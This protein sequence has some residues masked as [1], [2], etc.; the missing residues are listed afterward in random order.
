LHD[1]LL[2]IVAMKTGKKCWTGLAVLA[3]LTPGL[4][5][6]IAPPLAPPVPVAPPVAAA[7]AVPAAGG[8][9]RTLW[10]FLGVSK[11]QRAACKE[12]LCQRQIGQLFNNSLK[13]V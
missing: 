6:Q 2:G 11:E 9:G 1:T 5:A 7:P 8:N 12:W 10:S 3:G 13:P 4:R